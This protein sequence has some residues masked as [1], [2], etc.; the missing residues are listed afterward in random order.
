MTHA[1]TERADQAGPP[2]AL[3]M[4]GISK[5]FP[6]VQA[7]A[8][9]DL[10]VFGGQ[11]HAVVGENGAGKSTLMKILAGAYGADAGSI[12][13]EGRPVAFSS[14]HESQALGVGMVFQ[15]LNLVADLSVAENIYLGRQ[16]IRRF[17]IVDRRGLREQATA[18]LASLGAPIDATSLVRDLSVGQQ[19]MV[20]IAKVYSQDPRILVLDE[21]TS[22]LTEHETDILFATLRRL[23]SEGIAIIFISHRLKEVLAIADQ[24]TVLRDGKLV[25]SRPIGEL[26]AAEIV[27]MMVGRDVGD[28]FPKAVVDIG[29]LARRCRGAHDYGQQVALH[30][31]QPFRFKHEKPAVCPSFF[32]RNP[33]IIISRLY[34]NSAV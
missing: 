9:V 21:P 16:P 4:T 3:E 1:S 22:A 5:R 26:T 11:I 18:L 24:V 28:L 12:V 8:G 25:G 14:P 30:R 33:F 20:E 29:D 2:Y 31:H 13:M 23:R 6:G 19:Q 10:R 15:E 27:K 34:D 32:N 17:G 7:L